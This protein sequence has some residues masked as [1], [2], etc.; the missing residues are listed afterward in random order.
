[1]RSYPQPPAPIPPG[2]AG[3]ARR[4]GPEESTGERIVFTSR[5]NVA[6]QEF[7]VPRPGPEEVLVRT[8]VSVVSPGTERAL[9]FAE[10]NTSTAAAGFPFYPGYSS[11]GR[12]LAVG[13]AVTTVHQG[14]LLATM[15]GHQS[16]V[17]VRAP[18]TSPQQRSVGSL[19][20]STELTDM[21]WRMPAEPDA[22]M[23]RQSAT[24]MIATVGLF[25]AA[26]ADIRF[27]DEVVIAGLGPVGL[28]AGQFAR[29][30]GALTV[31]GIA[32]TPARRQAAADA[33]FDAA[34]ETLERCRQ[35]RSTLRPAARTV[36]IEATG[37][38]S[39]VLAALDFCPPGATLV[40]LGSSR[41]TVADVDF[42]SLVHR[43]AL[44]V[45]GAHQPTRPDGD[46]LHRRWKLYWD[47]DTALNMILKRR[48]QAQSLLSQRFSVAEVR[49]AY[50]AI[51]GTPDTQAVALDWNV[52]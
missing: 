28:F 30:S 29:L 12:V 25:G 38:P 42:Y 36:V 21:S 11:V 47:A 31:V 5:G 13:A 8:L 17:L 10:P 24:F 22:G 16:H 40:L 2:T 23:L 15:G 9:L 35:A 7:S 27:G 20:D 3:S 39:N 34:Y 1:M 49:A 43:K 41:G 51:A 44:R 33:G 48:V 14:E 50:A 4:D 19:F 52:R 46:Y 18:L 26:C 45:I 37:Q 32:R 6:L